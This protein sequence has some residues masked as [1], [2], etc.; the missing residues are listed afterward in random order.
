MNYRTC[1]FDGCDL[2]TYA[3]GFCR[4]HYA[5][6]RRTGTPDLEAKPTMEERFWAK[7]HPTGF[8]WEWTGCQSRGYGSF[9]RGRGRRKME[10]AHRVAYELLVAP[11]PEGQHIDHLCRNTL[12]VNPDHLEPV[13]PGVNVLRGFGLS[14]VAARRTHCG[15]GHELTQDNVWQNGRARICKTCRKLAERRRRS[16]AKELQAS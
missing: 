9:S 7:V 12:C 1:S 13:D 11:I 4:T 6:L 8:C 2:P 5:R 3:K 16:R 14:A 10:P 15:N